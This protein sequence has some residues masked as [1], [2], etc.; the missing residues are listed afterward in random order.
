MPTLSREEYYPWFNDSA[1]TLP[2]ERQLN[3]DFLKSERKRIEEAK[4]WRE[5][6]RSA[7]R[8]DELNE[9]ITYSIPV[10]ISKLL[11]KRVNERGYNIIGTSAL[12]NSLQSE[13]LALFPEDMDLPP[14]YAL[15]RIYDPK[16]EIVVFEGET[17]G[18]DAIIVEDYDVLPNDYIY[19]GVSS[20]NARVFDLLKEY[21]GG[22][23]LIT[24]SVYSPMISSPAT[25]TETGGIG[26]TSLT[27]T[28]EFAETLH[29]QVA[30]MLPREYTGYSPPDGDEHGYNERYSKG[31]GKK[32]IYKTAEKVPHR[33]SCVDFTKG[34]SYAKI[35]NQVQKRTEFTGEYSFLGN[36][37]PT[38]RRKVDVV[39]DTVNH[40]TQNEITISSYDELKLADV[41]LTRL[42]KNVSD[43][44]DF[45]TN[46]VDARQVMPGLDRQE[47]N[48]ERWVNKLKKDWE[49]FLPQMGYED[50]P[51]Q[52]SQLR[53]QQTYKNMLRMAQKIARSERREQVTKDDL[54][55]ARRNF[56]HQAERIISADVVKEATPAIRRSNT[57]DRESIVNTF[58]QSK[59]CK[60]EEL[61]SHLLDTKQFEKEQ[62]TESFVQRME[63]R[64]Y[65]YKTVDGRLHS[66]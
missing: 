64:G 56:T 51:H 27:R 46:I 52:I 37:I 44:E 13:M 18:T 40:F 20:N 45:W 57:A 9:Y 28:S 41:D 61:V 63:T 42:K 62:A 53:A 58:L 2:Q 39:Q 26:S 11:K 60:R 19:Q 21:L 36:L 50:S 1:A 30:L 10:D 43:Y 59:P 66:T 8:G 3:I 38:S 35:Q 6:Y 24:Q 32:I 16:K 34:A 4:E 65:I 48:K 22:D 33:Q 5:K 12:R 25:L 31:R 7:D 29:E 23:E 15:I 55:N 54:E 17:F 14:D 47:I 49:I